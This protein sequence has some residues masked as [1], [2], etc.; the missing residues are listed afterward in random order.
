MR[1]EESRDQKRLLAN[2]AYLEREVSKCY[3]V[4]ALAF[5]CFMVKYRRISAA[6][7]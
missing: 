1:V 2:L 6:A 5:S 4:Y 3:K 7:K